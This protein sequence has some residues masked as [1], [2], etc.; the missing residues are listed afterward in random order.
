MNG[1]PSLYAFSTAAVIGGL[2]LVTAPLH[3]QPVMTLAAAETGES[4]QILVEGRWAPRCLPAPANAWAKGRDLYFEV[5]TPKASCEDDA[6]SGFE[7]RS[8]PID[9]TTTGPDDRA[10]RLHLV[11]AESG[12]LLAFALEGGAG[13][14]DEAPESGL[15]WPQAGG[16]FDTSGPG[17]GVQIEVQGDTVALNVSGYNEFGAPTWWFGAAP[18]GRSGQAVEL[19]MLSGGAGPFGDYA[20]P[21]QIGSAGTLHI[22]WLG[23]AR[24]VFWFSRPAA[25]GRG[26]DL[27]P[28]S[29][30]R[31]AFATRPGE[32]WSGEWLLQRETLEA[33]SVLEVHRFEWLDGDPEGFEL[34][35][36]RGLRLACRRANGTPEQAP[37]ACQ[38]LPLGG[39]PGVRFA[40]VGL[41]AMVSHQDGARISLRRLR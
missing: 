2:L 1:S 3:A 18:L 7:L 6:K 8:G 15:W 22:E 16:E 29:M 34:L 36:D 14:A 12:R 30:T 5:R 4:R 31:F 41:D 37:K 13:A 40:D 27:R 21:Q 17:F 26:L 33:G 20:A 32:S 39:G 35:S 11:E 10:W 28:V 23:R 24:A 9:L 25:D 19:S 38:L